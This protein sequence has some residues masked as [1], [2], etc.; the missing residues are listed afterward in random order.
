MSRSGD[1]LMAGVPIFGDVAPMSALILIMQGDA[2]RDWGAGATGLYGTEF[3]VLCGVFYLADRYVHER[4]TI[5]MM[6][7]RDG[8]VQVLAVLSP[9]VAM[10]IL[11]LLTRKQHLAKFGPAPPGHHLVT[12]L[13]F[14]AWSLLF[15]LVEWIFPG[16]VF[17]ITVLIVLVI[18]ADT[19]T[20]DLLKYGWLFRSMGWSRKQQLRDSYVM[21]LLF[22]YPV[23]LLVSGAYA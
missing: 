2:K 6:H 17:G 21:A 13:L 19:M 8:M 11:V 7:G 23:V 5:C 18:Y 10:L 14:I 16:A 20:F 3:D 15:I 4:C 12:F 9:G 22:V 1:F